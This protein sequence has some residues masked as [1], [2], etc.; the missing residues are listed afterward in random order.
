MKMVMLYNGVRYEAEETATDLSIEDATKEFLDFITDSD[1]LR[2]KLI[3]GTYI[4]FGQDV[5][6]SSIFFFVDTPKPATKAK[7]TK[8]KA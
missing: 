5:I 1:V 2:L 3:D 8:T 6:R 7:T 4:V